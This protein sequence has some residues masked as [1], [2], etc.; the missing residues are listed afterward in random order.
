MEW[1]SGLWGRLAGAVQDNT[2]ATTVSVGAATVVAGGAIL[3]IYANR[4]RRVAH[5]QR[6]LQLELDAPSARR[7]EDEAAI[8][9]VPVRNPLAIGPTERTNNQ[10][11]QCR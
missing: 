10:L 4:Q 11:M 8:A 3:Y 9:A 5:Q 2:T 1:L 6:Q 7:G